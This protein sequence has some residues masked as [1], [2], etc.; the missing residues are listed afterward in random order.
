ME[1]EVPLTGYWRHFK[2]VFTSKKLIM[3]GVDEKNLPSTD[4]VQALTNSMASVAL[5]LPTFWAQNPDAWFYK[6][7][8]Q[9]KN[10]NIT[11]E[12]RRFYKVLA[13]LPE[14][15][16]IRVREIA[17]QG[18]FNPGDY[19]KLKQKLIRTRQPSTLERLDR[20]TELKNI[21]HKK[22][23]EILIDLEAIFHSAIV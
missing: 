20:L 13:V 15:A 22:P 23:S 19:E 10:A 18:Q 11:T 21:A 7:G 17:Q 8:A 14:S 4:T 12:Q 16:A 9:F 6:V 5:T 3:L 1:D 2:D